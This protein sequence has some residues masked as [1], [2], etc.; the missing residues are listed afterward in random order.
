MRA[1]RGSHSSNCDQWKVYCCDHSIKFDSSSA[2]HLPTAWGQVM[3]AKCSGSKKAV[4]ARL[5]VSRHETKQIHSSCVFQLHPALDMLHELG[6]K[7]REA[8]QT[9]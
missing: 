2:A 5:L 7:Q 8:M 1:V 3:H 9:C 6:S 4:H